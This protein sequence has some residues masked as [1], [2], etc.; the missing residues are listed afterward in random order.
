[1]LL[2]WGSHTSSVTLSFSSRRP[3]VAE[4]APSTANPLSVSPSKHLPFNSFKIQH[5]ELVHVL[6]ALIG[7]RATNIMDSELTQKFQVPTQR[8]QQPLSIMA[9]DVGPIQEGF[10]TIHIKSLALQVSAV[11]HETCTTIFFHH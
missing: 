7:S 4:K 6:S 11:H 1:M 5:S 9:I 2:L 10:V 8:F 3:T